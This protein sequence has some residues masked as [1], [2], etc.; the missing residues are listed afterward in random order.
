MFFAM[1]FFQNNLKDGM[2]YDIKGLEWTAWSNQIIV[3]SLSLIFSDF[4]CFQEPSSTES[5]LH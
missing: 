3:I 2:I 4:Q 5:V 1:I